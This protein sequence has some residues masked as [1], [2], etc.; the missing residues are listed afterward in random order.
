LCLPLG[1]LRFDWVIENPKSDHVA[2]HY[3]GVYVIYFFVR[4]NSFDVGYTP[5]GSEGVRYS[6]GPGEQDPQKVLDIARAQLP[7]ILEDIDKQDES[8]GI[9][10]DFTWRSFDDD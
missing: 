5:P 10:R 9:P 8:H 3:K 6:I 7:L 2:V 1:D 4:R